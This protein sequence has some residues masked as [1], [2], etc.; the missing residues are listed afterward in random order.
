MVDCIKLSLPFSSWMSLLGLIMAAMHIPNLSQHKDLTATLGTVEVKTLPWVEGTRHAH[1]KRRHDEQQT[2]ADLVAKGVNP[3]LRRH[4][5][6]LPYLG[7]R[8]CPFT[9]AFATHPYSDYSLK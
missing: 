5:C 3:A 1:G 9:A 4:C 2:E 7:I 6:F 8:T